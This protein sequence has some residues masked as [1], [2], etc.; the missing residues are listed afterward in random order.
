MEAALEKQDLFI[1]TAVTTYALSMLWEAFRNGYL[2]HHGVFLNLDTKRASPMPINPLAWQ[3][4]GWR[5]RA[6]RGKTAAKHQDSPAQ[7]KPQERK[8]A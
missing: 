2:T 7:Q 1:N 6:K 5:T 8:A 3:R 4:T